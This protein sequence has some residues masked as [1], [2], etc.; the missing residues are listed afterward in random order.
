MQKHPS[1]ILSQ[2]SALST[3]T[4]QC[5]PYTL[6]E[7]LTIEFRLYQTE[8]RLDTRGLTEHQ[9][10]TR[11]SRDHG[12]VS[13]PPP[14]CVWSQHRQK[15]DAVRRTHHH[16]APG[17]ANTGEGGIFPITPPP[18]SS[19]LRPQA[20][21]EMPITDLPPRTEDTNLEGPLLPHILPRSL[22]IAQVLRTSCLTWSGGCPV[23]RVRS[24]PSSNAHS[25]LSAPRRY[26]ESLEEEH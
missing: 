12:D 14:H 15:G 23:L 22:F 19:P 9:H 18:R 5:V 4:T 8:R 20:F 1:G 21:P 7:T 11:T 13:R 10:Q 25:Q 17:R 3:F 2:F 16:A 26:F 6:A 24:A